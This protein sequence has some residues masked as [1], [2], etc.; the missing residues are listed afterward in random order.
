MAYETGSTTGY[1]DFITKL[2]A[3]LAA[4][5][6]TTANAGNDSTGGNAFVASRGVCFVYFGP[7]SYSESN[8]YVTATRETRTIWGYRMG[9]G[10]GVGTPASI[11]NPTQ[12]PGG[13]ATAITLSMGVT[14][15]ATTAYHFFTD[16]SGNFACSF[17]VLGDRYHHFG[18]GELDKR[19]LTHSGVAFC[20][21]QWN[22]EYNTFSSGRSEGNSPTKRPAYGGGRWNT[23]GSNAAG[24]WTQVR[25]IN[26]SPSGRGFPEGDVIVAPSGILSVSNSVHTATPN[27]IFNTQSQCDLLTQLIQT[28]V[29]PVGNVSPM[30]AIPI[31]IKSTGDRI[32]YVGDIPM[33]R[34]LRIEHLNPGDEITI[35]GSET[36][37]TFPQ[38]R[39]TLPS[40]IETPLALTSG[41]FGVAF[42]KVT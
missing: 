5:G 41:F 22:L 40:L 2:R 17:E 7:Y 39:K 31:F 10:T 26:V 42:R 32:I 1:A 20:S 18:F 14:D 19:G 25:L 29:L 37:K 35:A 30:S 28:P 4:N 12:M 33:F 34:R 15:G 38:F 3:F 13:N 16:A 24:G 27:A 11:L 9:L 23:N 21:A 6:W 36:W 8:Y